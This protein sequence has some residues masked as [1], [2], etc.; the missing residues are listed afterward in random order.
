[1]PIIATWLSDLCLGIWSVVGAFAL[2]FGLLS[3]LS[4]ARTFVKGVVS[5]ALKDP[6]I[7]SSV[8]ALVKP[9]LVF[10][11]NGAVLSDRGAWA[12]IKENGITITKGANDKAVTKGLP[13]TIRIA[14]TKHLPTAPLLTPIGPDVIFVTSTGGKDC[15]W[16]YTLR[17]SM[18]SDPD[19]V[20][21]VRTYRLEL[22]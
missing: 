22:L 2:V 14:F 17:Y 21:V 1:M 4:I 10:D 18:R 5:E 9:D 6:S 8:A 12:A 7:L 16:V 15:E 20:A 11:E 13:V 19:D 3:S